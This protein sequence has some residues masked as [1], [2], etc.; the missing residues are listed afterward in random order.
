M[1]YIASTMKVSASSTIPKHAS[2]VFKYDSMHGIF[3]GE[4]S[5]DE[6]GN[7]IVNGNII[8]MYQEKSPAKIPWRDAGAEKLT[9]WSPA[10]SSLLRKAQ[11][12]LE[13]GARK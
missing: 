3:N 8:K 4:A 2:Y 13:G 11:G 10:A 9:S 6:P 5:S 1:T 12:H 7:L